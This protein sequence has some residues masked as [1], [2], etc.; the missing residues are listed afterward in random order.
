MAKKKTDKLNI[1]RGQIVLSNLQIK[2][3]EKAQRIAAA[4]NI[5]EEE[6]GIHEVDII[7][8]NC[9]VCPWITLDYLNNTE[10]EKLLQGILR[11][12]AG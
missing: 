9:F 6:G 11:K 2:S 8:D 1:E 10:M 3:L 12:L 5:I 7:L 4:I